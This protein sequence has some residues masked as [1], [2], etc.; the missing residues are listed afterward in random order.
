MFWK[1][2]LCYFN[3][4]SSQTCQH[5]EDIDLNLLTFLNNAYIVVIH[6]CSC[7]CVWSNSESEDLIGSQSEPIIAVVGSL[8]EL[9]VRSCRTTPTVVYVCPGTCTCTRLG[10]CTCT[11]LVGLPVANG[12]EF[13]SH[14]TVCE[15]RNHLQCIESLS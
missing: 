4:D 13:L 10:T 3:A 12:S 15:I 2:T 14:L 7:V 9:C 6:W 8:R 1:V 11:R 5:L